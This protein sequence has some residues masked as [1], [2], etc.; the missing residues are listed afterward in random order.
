MRRRDATDWVRNAARER[1]L[2][3]N[4]ESAATLVERFGSDIGSLASALD[5]LLGTEEAITPELIRERFR[6]RPDEPMWHFTDAVAAGDVDDA[7]RRLHD[8][9]THS[10][11]LILLA[12]LENDLRKRALAAAAPD[13]ETFAE[14]SNSKPEAFPTR[15][16]WNARS[17]MTPE[18]LALA[19]DAL[20]R[21]DQT[22]KTKPEETHLVTLE[23]LTVSL[24]YW[25]S[26]AR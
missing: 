5:Q 19:V 10:H 9:I 24:C 12:F 21:A 8:F 16:A 14:W 4:A 15:K 11:P 20:R 3:V 25:Y 1:K 22:L 2:K 6:N 7:L 23:R 17:R 26:A 13:I 18:R